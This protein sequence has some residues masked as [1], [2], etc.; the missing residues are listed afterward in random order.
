MNEVAFLIEFILS[1]CSDIKV[2]DSKTKRPRYISVV[3]ETTRSKIDLA[4]GFQARALDPFLEIFVIFEVDSCEVEP[5]DA[6]QA[7]VGDIDISY[8]NP[9]VGPY[10]VFEG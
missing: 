4:G 3:G 6:R 8:I 10:T 7:V 9:L 2:A 5:C 1:R